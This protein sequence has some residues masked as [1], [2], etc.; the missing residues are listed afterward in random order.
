MLIRLIGVKLS[1]LV[2]G[3]YQIDLFN[4]VIEDLNL[5]QAMDGIRTRFGVEKINRGICF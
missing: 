2:A 3:S 1:D 4:D 5:M